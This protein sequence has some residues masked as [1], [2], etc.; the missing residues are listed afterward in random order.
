MAPLYSAQMEIQ[1]Q[2]HI[3]RNFTLQNITTEMAIGV[4][5]VY[6]KIPTVE[7]WYYELSP[8]VF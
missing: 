3:Q 8:L 2:K 1:I 5:W 4:K 6:I 7:G